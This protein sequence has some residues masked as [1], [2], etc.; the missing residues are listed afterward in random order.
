[1]VYKII[2]PNTKGRI[3][4]YPLGYSSMSCYVLEYAK[5]NFNLEKTRVTLIIQ[6][7]PR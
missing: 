3:T 2:L 4:E 6:G 5:T 1:M 7:K